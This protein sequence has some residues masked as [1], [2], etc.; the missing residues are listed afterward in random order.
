M[1]TFIIDLILG[2]HVRLVKITDRGLPSLIDFSLE[3]GE[4][5]IY[6]YLPAYLVQS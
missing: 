6:Q 1:T 5:D 4:E 3:G 2:E